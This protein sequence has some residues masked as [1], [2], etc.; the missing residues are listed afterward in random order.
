MSPA[1]PDRPDLRYPSE[2][3]VPWTVLHLINWSASYLESKGI[4]CARLDAEHLLA[5]VLETDRLG[6]YLE[7]DRPVRT[8]DLNRFKPLLLDRS[9][10]KPLQ[11]VL[12]RTA[13]RGMELVTDPRVLIPRPETEELV[14]AVLKHVAEWGR[15]RLRALDVGTGCGAI[16]LALAQEEPFD[17]VLATDASQAA[18]DVAKENL[19]SLGLEKQVEL[20][21]GV[22]LGVVRPAERFHVL[23]SNPP[24]VSEEDFRELQPEVRDWEPREALVAGSGGLA[25]LSDLVE[26]ASRVLEVGGLLALEVGFGQAPSIAELIRGTRGFESPV[27]MR[28]LCGTERVVLS[29]WRG[30]GSVHLQGKNSSASRESLAAT[31]PA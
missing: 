8:E 28:D 18:L 13:F 25:V 12:G 31:G 30:E 19:C 6:L 21:H 3:G 4:E 26:G 22:S 5:H 20:R 1:A 29:R 24:Y 7:F 10:R 15:G 27:V 9:R 14:E 23:V 11:Y 17:H 2:E 16:A